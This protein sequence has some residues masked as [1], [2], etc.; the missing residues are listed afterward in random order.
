[1]KNAILEEK[2]R[3]YRPMLHFSVPK[4]W[5][6]DPNGLLYHDGYYH[7]FYQHHPDGVKH[8]P[9]HWGHAR[10]TDFITWEHLPI[11]LYPDEHGTI[12]SGS[13]VY[14]EK[15]T[16][17]MARDGV[18]PLVAVYTYHKET[19][20]KVRQTQ[21]IAFS[22]DG[23]MTFE[24]YEGNPVLDEDRVDFRDP[25]VFW[26]EDENGGKW[27]MP[28][29]AGRVVRLYGSY[30]LKDW[31][32][33]STFSVEN[34]EPA[35]IWECPDLRSVRTESGE[36][37]WVFSV[38]VN[39]ED[40]KYYGMQYFV[41]EFDGTT[42]TPEEADRI[43]MQDVGIDDYAAVTYEGTEDRSILLGW[44]NCWYYAD[45][46]PES[47]FR[48]S[49]MF[50]RE[51]V[52]GRRGGHWKLLQKPVRELTAYVEEKKAQYK[53]SVA[54]SGVP[55]WIKADIH[56]GRNE[57]ILRNEESAFKIVIDTD[58]KKLSMDRSGCGQEELGETFL[59]VQEG[60]YDGDICDSAVVIVDTTSVEVF[61]ADGELCGTMQ[62][63]TE[64][65][66]TELTADA[67][68]TVIELAELTDLVR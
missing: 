3:E 23:G 47:G 45:Q 41:G 26:Y 44:M 14:D 1:M 13:M 66:F 48:G 7:L 15:N 49:M 32:Y 39:T 46:I 53:G 24:K 31:E 43:N 68:E 12:F 2:Y 62:Y 57:L 17:G 67:E 63:F 58:A 27:I 59:K 56:A 18:C 10:T 65:P 28:L 25:K 55:A 30:N 19:Q 38:S 61:T 5:M 52:A 16:A 8:G 50:P 11:A 22:Y 21:G 34:P 9:M 33:L 4:G 60:V 37:K 51:T 64:K 20:G 6:N 42:F 29:V 40:R 54:L 35:G 36:T